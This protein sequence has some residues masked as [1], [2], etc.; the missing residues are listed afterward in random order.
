[1]SVTPRPDREP[2]RELRLARAE[3]ADEAQQVARP[4]DGRQPG[5]EGAG[6]LGVRRRD[7]AFAGWSGGHRSEGSRTTR[8]SPLAARRRARPCGPVRPRRSRS[9]IGNATG[10]RP[11]IATKRRLEL[12]AALEP[13]QPGRPRRA[14]PRRRRSV[15]SGPAPSRASIVGRSSAVGLEHER[16]RVDQQRRPR[17]RRAARAARR[18]A[19]GS[20]RR[21]A[22]SRTSTPNGGRGWSEARWRRSEA[23]KSRQLLAGQRGDDDPA[24]A[25][26]AGPGQRLGVDPRADDEDAPRSADVDAARAAARRTGR[27]RARARP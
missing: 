19:S 17:G 10:A 18:P 14:G 4:R 11:P 27:S 15:P 2:L 6:R 24:H 1:M 3:V 7:D 5:G 26:R 8:G 13:P 22:P 12:H 9:P 21:T 20:R 25:H 23:R 16:G